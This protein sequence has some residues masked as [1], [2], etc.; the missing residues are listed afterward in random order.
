VQDWADN[1]ILNQARIS[2]EQIIAAL[3]THCNTNGITI[4]TGEDAQVAQAY[5]LEVVKMA[6]VRN[7]E[8]EAEMAALAGEG[9]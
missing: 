4:A 2:K 6:A 7:A 3:V 9:D 1:A 8:A 5:D